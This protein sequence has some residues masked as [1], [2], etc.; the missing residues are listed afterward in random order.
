MSKFLT[1]T[2]LVEQQLMHQNL[3]A[4]N[5]QRS[6]N[7]QALY[8]AWLQSENARKNLEV[9]VNSL[10]SEILALKIQINKPNSNTKDNTVITTYETDEELARETEWVRVKQGEKKTKRVGIPKL[11]GLIGKT[12]GIHQPD[13]R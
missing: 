8:N 1:S 12:V 7:E 3:F 11:F 2:T 13:A 5:A 10:E 9:T 6:Q 4:E